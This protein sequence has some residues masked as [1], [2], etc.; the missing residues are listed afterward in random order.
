MRR[1]ATYSSNAQHN[2]FD[3]KTGRAAVP[4]VRGEVMTIEAWYM[5]KDTS[6]DQRLPHRRTPNVECD[7]SS[8]KALGEMKRRSDKPADL[9]GRHSIPRNQGHFVECDAFFAACHPLG[10][11]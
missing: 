6:S 7:T 3:W 9:H 8:L 2:T 5:D 10:L 1:Y 11:H 4:L